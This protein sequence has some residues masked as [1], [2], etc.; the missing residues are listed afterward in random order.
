M[1]APDACGLRPAIIAACFA[2]LAA[3]AA[4]SN[5]EAA[6]AFRYD[7]QGAAGICQ[8]AR[9]EYGVALRARPLGL[10]NEGTVPAFVTCTLRGDPRAGGRGATKVLVHL[11]NV[12]TASAVVSCT[13]VEGRQ[14]GGES[15]AVYRTKS[16][17]LFG[18]AQGESFSWQPSEIAGGPEL[19][20]QPALQCSLGAG[21]ALHYISVS[22][23]EDVGA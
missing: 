10:V 21:S 13:F 16:G 9:P 17:T 3:A 4:S 11:G 15:N 14:L 7:I 5:L 12:G 6:E 22:Y 18:G 8:P 19:I 1:S 20:Y 23:D 2:L